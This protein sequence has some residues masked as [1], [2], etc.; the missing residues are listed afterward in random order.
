MVKELFAWYRKVLIPVNPTLFGNTLLLGVSVPVFLAH[1]LILLISLV[2]L[3]F[4]IDTTDMVIDFSRDTTSALTPI[5]SALFGIWLLYSYLFLAILL[6]PLAL[7]LRAGVTGEIL[8]GACS[9]FLRFRD[10][11]VIVWSR[12]L[13][14]TSDYRT[15]FIHTKPPQMILK[16]GVPHHLA[17]GWLPSRDPMLA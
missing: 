5:V 7:I 17:A 2:L 8:D 4:G 13:A 14:T 10:R 3:T 12:A 15:D 9:A 1:L 11:V 16:G 6:I